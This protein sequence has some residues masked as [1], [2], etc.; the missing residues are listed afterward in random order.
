MLYI[1][2]FTYLSPHEIDRAA[3]ILHLGPDGLR[4]LSDRYVLLHHER[5]PS[6]NDVVIHEI[7]YDDF[8]D[9]PEIEKLHQL[10]EEY[11][12]EIISF[13]FP[14]KIENIK[15]KVINTIYFA[16]DKVYK[17]SSILIVFLECS[18]SSIPNTIYTAIQEGF[19][20]EDEYVNENMH[21]VLIQKRSDQNDRESS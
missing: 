18:G 7:P 14:K 11:P 17:S 8:R 21:H 20:I 10:E 13:V 4:E 3:Q 5:N 1:L 12:S 9:T 19:Q 15:R 2:S 16:M 6:L